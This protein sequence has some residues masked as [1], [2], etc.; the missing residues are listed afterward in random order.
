MDRQAHQQKLRITKKNG[1]IDA[2]SKKK[3][4]FAV[5]KQQ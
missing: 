3:H 4:T 2:F 1:L 5:Q